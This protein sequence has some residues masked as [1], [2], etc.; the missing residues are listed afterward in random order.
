MIHG[1]EEREQ[2][3]LANSDRIETTSCSSDRFVT[4]SEQT[5]V[6]ARQV[7][8]TLPRLFA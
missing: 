4:I 6:E 3:P 2:A 1:N 5:V 8:D 7:P